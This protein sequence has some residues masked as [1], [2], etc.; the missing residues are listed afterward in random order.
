[1][2]LGGAL[3]PA[4]EDDLEVQVAP[5]RLREEQL[6]VGFRLLHAAPVSQAP[7]L[8][9]PLHSGGRVEV[10]WGRGGGTGLLL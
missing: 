1:M 4:E 7:A 5:Q 6:Q 10:G 2:A 3:F 8:R 9:Q